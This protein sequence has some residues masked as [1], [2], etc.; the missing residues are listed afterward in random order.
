MRI[1]GEWKNR[2]Y[3]STDEV[4]LTGEYR[5]VHYRSH[6]DLEWDAHPQDIVANFWETTERHD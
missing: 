2:E 6:W 1:L 3:P 4:R 5:S